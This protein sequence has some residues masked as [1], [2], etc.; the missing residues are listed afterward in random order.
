MFQFLRF[1]RRCWAMSNY[2][3]HCFNLF[4]SNS[5][6][7]DYWNFS[8]FFYLLIERLLWLRRRG[9]FLL[10]LDLKF[11]SLNLARYFGWRY[12]F[13]K[14]FLFLDYLWASFWYLSFSEIFLGLLDLKLTIWQG[15][16]LHAFFKNNFSSY[17]APDVRM[18]IF[19]SLTWA[20]NLIL[21]D[22]ASLRS[23]KWTILISF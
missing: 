10:S 2:I 17:W 11:Y 3:S 1:L 4:C 15:H 13:N 21:I 9:L 16:R 19:G 7:I 14:L 22:I 23:I 8:G 6:W 5:G 18:L 12:S 20:D